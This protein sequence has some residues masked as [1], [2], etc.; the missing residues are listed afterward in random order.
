ML[1]TYRELSQILRISESY[2]RAWGKKLI[3]AVK[4]GSQ[5]R[6]KL[7]DVLAYIEKNKLELQT[8]TT[9]QPPHR[10]VGPE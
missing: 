2:L 5:V 8:E 7:S 4:F 10:E 1:L 6:F 9:E 3:P